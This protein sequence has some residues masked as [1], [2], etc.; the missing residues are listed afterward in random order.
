MADT[1]RIKSNIQRMIDQGATESEIDSYVSSEGVT[2]AEL[3]S[4][5]SGF[6]EKAAGLNPDQLSMA[7]AKNDDFGQYLR[8]EAKKPLQGESEADRAQRLYG[9]KLPRPGIGEGMARAGLKGLTFGFGDEIVGAGAAALDSVVRGDDFSQAY[10]MRRDQERNK[11]QQFQQDHP[12]LAVGTEIAGAI[13]TSI[14]PWMNLA[15][16]FKGASVA[17]TLLKSAGIGAAQ[18]GV[19]GFG[20][21]EGGMSEQALSAARGAGLGMTGAGLGHIASK[22]IQKGVN[23]MMS[24]RVAN[25]GGMSYPEW[26]MLKNNMQVDDSL[27]GAGVERMSRAGPNAVLAD[28]G[29]GGATLLDQA[30]TQSPLAANLARQN[31]H[32]R[33]VAQ[34]SILEDTMNRTMGSP[35]GLRGINK[36][37]G[38]STAAQRGN[39]YEA[40]YNTAIDYSSEA[41]RRIEQQLERMSPRIKKEAFET[42]N[43]RMLADGV[44]NQQFMAKIADDGSITFTNPPNVQQLDYLKRALG[45]MG[46][47]ATDQFG[48]LTDR[49]SMLSGLGRDLKNALVDAVGD[50]YSKA[51]RFGQDKIQREEALR[52][53]SKLFRP[54]TTREMVMDMAEDMSDEARQAAAQGVRSQID[55][56]LAQVKRTAGGP[57]TDGREAIKL[58]KDL[59]SRANKE[60]LQ[61]I[62]GREPA[63]ELLGQLDNSSVAFELMSRVARGSQ[64]AGR[65]AAEKTANEIIEGGAINALRRGEIIQAPKEV[66]KSILGRSAE[67]KQQIKDE[68]YLNLVKS[69]TG[70]R[71]ADATRI[72]ERIS[73]MEPQIVDATAAAGKATQNIF[74]RSTAGTAPLLDAYRT[75]GSN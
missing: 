60:K 50:D 32:G 3:Q 71:G 10:Q 15:K 39:A 68:L 73:R 29:E 54:G 56:M 37:I 4:S 55:E 30:I 2:A 44:K 66:V 17:P 65:E 6:P 62:L 7:R 38:Q 27:T 46:R 12:V 57:D 58:I 21:G 63:N 45:S 31:V 42:A 35:Q 26:Q 74:N 72:L 11:Q 24:G 23:R 19:Y 49:G 51:L 53:G 61:L 33:A 9:S 52:L 28:A 64:T 41:G 8:D 36:N 47:E 40:A 13:P 34:R 67:A 25:Q 70:P 20:E 59:S 22:G 5:S 14:L 75:E 18:G 48:S 69:L 43:E 1:A 16:T